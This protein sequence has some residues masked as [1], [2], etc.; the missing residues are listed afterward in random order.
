LNQPA[1]NSALAARL[2]EVRATRATGN[3]KPLSL[4]RVSLSAGVDYGHVHRVF[5]GQSLPS[6]EILVK[7]CQ[8]LDCSR[9]ERKDIF[10]AAGYVSPDELEEEERARAA[11]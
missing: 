2:E 11:A 4:R 10:H 6:P 5:H 3:G 9:E 7:I 8:A 1:R